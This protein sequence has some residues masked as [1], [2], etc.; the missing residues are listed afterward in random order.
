[1]KGTHREAAGKS[2]FALT[3]GLDGGETVVHRLKAGPVSCSAAGSTAVFTPDTGHRAMD[4][5][6]VMVLGAGMV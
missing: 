2:F 3:Q 1:M 4:E 5:Y 6:D